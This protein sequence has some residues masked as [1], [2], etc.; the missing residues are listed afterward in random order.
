MLARLEGLRVEVENRRAFGTQPRALVVRRQEAVAPVPRAALREGEFGHHDV[1]GQVLVHRAEAVSRPRAERGI[2][3]EPAA[4]VHVKQ[5][6]GMVQRLRLAAAIV[7]QFIGHEWIGEIL[8][9]VAHLDARLADLVELERAADEK[10]EPGLLPFRELRLGLVQRAELRLRIKG[11]HV[12]RTALHEKHDDV[13]RLR[14]KHRR[15]GRERIADRRGWRGE[16]FT[17]EQFREG[18]RAERGAETV[19]H[20]AARDRV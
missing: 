10:L 9:L 11:V 1:A 6:L 2:G 17:R 4:G 3:A 19:Q 14:G 12:P 18:E 5:R 16:S 15:L 7:A 13:L 20:L 8:P